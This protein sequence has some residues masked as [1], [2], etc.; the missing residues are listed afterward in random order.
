MPSMT[1]IRTSDTTTSIAFAETIWRACAP[2]SATSTWHP[3]CLNHSAM[4]ERGQAH[5]RQ[6]IWWHPSVAF[7]DS[8]KKRQHKRKASVIFTFAEVQL[9]SVF[10]NNG[11]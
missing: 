10:V 6:A 8:L 11:L 2:S 9:S 3:S 4:I 1:G 7:S 5:H